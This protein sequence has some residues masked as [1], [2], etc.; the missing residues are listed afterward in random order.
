MHDGKVYALG[1]T[2]LLNCLDAATGKVIWTRDAKEDAGSRRS[3]WG[4]AS[5]P[6]V[7][8][9]LVTVFTGGPKDKS[10]SAYD[11]ANGG[12]RSGRRAKGTTVTARRTPR[13]SATSN[14][15]SSPLTRD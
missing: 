5:S 8:Q 12:G 2:G 9:G 13:G 1:G 6:L 14:K 15:S 4:F 3:M 7:L 11:A 10:V